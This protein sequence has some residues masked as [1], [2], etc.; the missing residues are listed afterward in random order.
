MTSPFEYIVHAWTRGTSRT[1]SMSSRANIRCISCGA[2]VV[3]VCY[4]VVIYLIGRKLLLQVL[5]F[6]V[7]TRSTKNILKDCTDTISAIGNL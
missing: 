7:R 5:D 4:W 3:M 2:D 6:L 1:A